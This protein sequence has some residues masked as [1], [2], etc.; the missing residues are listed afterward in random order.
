MYIAERNFVT[1]ATR[2]MFTL[3]R[4]WST[5][6]GCLADK[7]QK[8]S[9]HALSEIKK[10]AF[11]VEARGVYRAATLCE[12]VLGRLA[13]EST[14]KVTAALVSLQHLIS[15]YADGLIEID[16]E[17]E[18][19][20]NPELPVAEQRSDTPAPK[21]ENGS[22]QESAREQAINVLTPLMR[23]VKDDKRAK[24]LSILMRPPNEHKLEIPVSQSVPFDGL[25]RPITNL[26]LSEARHTG[27]NI[28]VS[29]AADFDDLERDTATGMQNFLEIICLNIVSQGISDDQS[30]PARTTQMSITGQTRDNHY[31]FTLSWIGTSLPTS[32]AATSHTGAAYND[33]KAIGGSFETRTGALSSEGHAHQSLLVKYPKRRIAHLP[34]IENASGTEPY[35]ELGAG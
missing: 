16:P 21:Q 28:S 27:K 22:D 9:S 32:A 25:M 23:L 4:I 17:F 2:Q 1:T 31:Q 8:L 12:D 13:A 24:A 35:A 14:A 6:A 15:Q 20:Q 30:T 29:Y 18:L 26:I 11:L 5:P 19:P 34:V 7:N 33:L 10:A 3:E